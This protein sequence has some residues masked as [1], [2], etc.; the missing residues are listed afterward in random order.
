MK[1]ATLETGKFCA[2]WHF[3]ANYFFQII[4]QIVLTQKLVL[5]KS[6][7]NFPL[8]EA[9][10]RVIFHCHFFCEKQINNNFAGTKKIGNSYRLLSRPSRASQHRSFSLS[11]SIAKKI[12]FLSLRISRL[13]W[14]HAV[15][16][17]I[18]YIKS[19]YASM[20]V[21]SLKKILHLFP[22]IVCPIGLTEKSVAGQKA[23][24][25]RTVWKQEGGPSVPSAILQL[26]YTNIK[27]P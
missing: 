7:D 18:H 25:H 10:A 5:C 3:L 12:V 14:R 15:L 8:F 1:F 19:I 17:P 9:N 21:P 16:S 23:S 22:A 2:F 4:W 24:R 20:T 6:G 26:N 13:F 11:W 27:T